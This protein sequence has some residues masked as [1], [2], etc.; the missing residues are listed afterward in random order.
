MGASAVWL[1]NEQFKLPRSY[2]PGIAVGD[3]FATGITFA[4]DTLV[5]AVTDYIVFLPVAAWVVPWSSNYV[6]FD[7][8][9]LLD[10][11]V[12]V[13][14]GVPYTGD[15]GLFLYMTLL[16]GDPGY[17]LTVSLF[18]PG[19]GVSLINFEKEPANYWLPTEWA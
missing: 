2:L 13:I 1:N 5:W 14:S 3:L 4:S 17:W 18:T 19:P 9:F 10:E 8:I 15:W 12:L 16:D 6:R 11:A 7:K